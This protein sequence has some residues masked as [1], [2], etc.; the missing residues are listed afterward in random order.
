[1]WTESLEVTRGAL[2]VGS[3]LF[4]FVFFQSV[5]SLTGISAELPT[6][7]SKADL[8]LCF[9]G[10]EDL[11][12]RLKAAKP[13]RLPTLCD[14]WHSLAAPWRGLFQDVKSRQE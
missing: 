9:Q 11:V 3:V 1:M 10:V 2:L 14:P 4:I 8:P 7:S 6:W 5:V 13:A 12:K